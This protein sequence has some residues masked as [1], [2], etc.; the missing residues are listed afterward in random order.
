MYFL[1]ILCFCMVG[2]CYARTDTEIRAWFF[3]QGVECSKDHPVTV[4]EMKLM[5]QH[6]FP[7]SR[8]SKCIGACVFKRANWL[9]SKG[10]FDIEQATAFS[11]KE[12][13]DNPTKLEAGKKIFQFCKKVNDEPVTDGED[14]CDRAL[15]LSKCLIGNA[16]EYGF[17]IVP[18]D[19][20][21]E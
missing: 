1:V 17:E 10:M 11:E 7:E 4:E 19:G 18:T 6:Q 14:G 21:E 15:L 20:P 16:K 2:A 9:D 13:A 8:N 3:R 12:Y 5:H